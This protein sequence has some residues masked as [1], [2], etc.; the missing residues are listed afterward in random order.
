MLISDLFRLIANK[1]LS[2]SLAL[3]PADTIKIILTATEDGK[4]KRPHQAFLV[5]QDPETGLEIPYTFAMRPEGKGKVDFVSS[6]FSKAM[7][8]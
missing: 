2:K 5:L 7:D 8:S 3:G 1:P 4:A 6:L